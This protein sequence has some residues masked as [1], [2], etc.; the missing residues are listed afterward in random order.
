MLASRVVRKLIPLLAVL[1]AATLTGCGDE[2]AK[3]DPVTL[4]AFLNSAVT[5]GQRNAVERRMQ[6]VPTAR[7]V[8]RTSKEQAYARFKE[9]YK[10][11]PDLVA[12]TKPDALPESFSATVANG[13][14]AEAAAAAIRALPGVDDMNLAPGPG[15]EKAKYTGIVVYLK[16]DV[17][18]GERDQIRTKIRAVPGI[19]E[20]KYE[21]KNE[22]YDRFQDV[23]RK[24]PDLAAAVDRGHVS[25][26]FRVKLV[27]NRY[28]S[29]GVDSLRTLSGVTTLRMLPDTAL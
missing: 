23:F 28:S 21:S 2:V 10:N 1:L 18:K 19:M 25:A 5:A 8:T 3:A 27:A 9:L 7:D 14:Y 26:S 16:D 11:S 6:A 22:A 13:A 20:S 12:Q 17:T 29:A 4:T 15:S 24:Q